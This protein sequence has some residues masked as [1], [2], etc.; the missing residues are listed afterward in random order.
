MIDITKGGSVQPSSSLWVGSINS[1]VYAK[2][3]LTM[4][5]CQS[6][7]LFGSVELR[8]RLFY[9]PPN[10]SMEVGVWQVSES[11]SEIGDDFGER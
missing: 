1:L 8:C 10:K 2:L 3:I 6:P 9:T 5:P 11:K 4:V 7:G